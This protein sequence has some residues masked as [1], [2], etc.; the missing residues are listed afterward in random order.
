MAGCADDRNLLTVAE[1]DVSRVPRLALPVDGDT[2]GSSGE[3]GAQGAG[4]RRLARR[5]GVLAPM[6]PNR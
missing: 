2:V 4:L 1:D 5:I 3:V 6:N